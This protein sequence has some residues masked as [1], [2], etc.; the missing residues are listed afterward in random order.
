[1]LA[2]V[3]AARPALRAVRAADCLLWARGALAIVDAA[4][5]PEPL[6]RT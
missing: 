5:S 1:M 4:V 2:R 3:L 6:A